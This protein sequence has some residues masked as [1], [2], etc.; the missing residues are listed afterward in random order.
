MIAGGPA[1]RA[2]AGMV[3]VS[4]WYAHFFD[5]RYDE[6]H[7]EIE[8]L[9]TAGEVAGVTAWLDLRPGMRVL[10]VPCGA[11]RHAVELAARGIEVTGLDL[12]E[13]MLARARDRA[14]RRGVTVEWVQGDMREIP[15]VDRFDAVINLFNSFGYFGD[16]GDRRALTGMVRALRPG[17]RQLLDLPNRDCYVNQVPPSYWDETST[18]WVLCAFRFDARTGTAV[19]DYTFVPKGGGVPE[20]RETRMRW[21]TLPELEAWLREAGAAV[22][23]VY[24]DWDGSPFEGD[25]PRMIIIAGRE[26]GGSPAPA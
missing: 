6:T 17:G 4:G 23:A 5:E 20:H 7:R 10:D 3:P 15:W 12:S 22:E 13:R 1:P 2:A 16:D 18:H 9:T 8:A 25:S 21:Y 11:G 24:G 19:I 26:A 14:A